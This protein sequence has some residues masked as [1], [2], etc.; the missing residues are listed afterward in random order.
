MTGLL[1]VLGLPAAV[2]YLTVEFPKRNKALP[3]LVVRL[4]D[5]RILQIEFQSKNDPRIEWRCLEY[6][7]LISEQWPGSQVVQ[8]VIYLGDGPLKMASGITRGDLKFRF[9]VLNLQDVNADVFL[10]SQNDNERMLAVLCKSAEPRATIA[11]ILGSWKHLPAKE[12]REKIA[13]LF[14]L[15]QLRKRDTIVK[16]ESADMPVELD[17]TENALYKI[18]KAAGEAQGA[19]LGEARGEAKLLTKFLER[20]FGP[21]PDAIRS[22]ISAADVDALDQWA[23][24][25]D[26]AQTLDE[27]FADET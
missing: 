7:Q 23:D 5:G 26:T 9:H 20:R 12:V 8:V 27:V 6:W 24:R 15:S 11:A 3:D 22:R 10:S 16:E 4:A 2:D 17:I 14:V 13:N 1:R 21:L 25:M 18:A 19:A